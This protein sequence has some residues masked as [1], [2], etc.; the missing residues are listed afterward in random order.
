MSTYT[1]QLLK[2]EHILKH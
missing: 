1:T 2:Y